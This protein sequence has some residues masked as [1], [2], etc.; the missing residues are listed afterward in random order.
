MTARAARPDSAEKTVRDIPR[1]FLRQYS[2]EEKR[3]HIEAPLLHFRGLPLC[4]WQ[5]DPAVGRLIC[6]HLRLLP[7]VLYLL[8]DRI[9]PTLAGGRRFNGA[10]LPVLGNHYKILFV[11]PGNELFDFAD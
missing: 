4:R 6:A 7:L 9:P 3:C 5:L 8:N 2:A 1:A 11:L 10:T